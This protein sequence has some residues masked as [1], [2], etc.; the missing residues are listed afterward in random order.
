MGLAVAAHAASV[1][2]IEWVRQP[3]ANAAKV[4]KLAH[5]KGSGCESR[6]LLPRN[7]TGHRRH[8]VPWQAFCVRRP[9]LPLPDP[10]TPDA[11]LTA[12]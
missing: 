3:H 7:H 6:T 9:S 8:P 10:G 12:P 11:T 5:H 2:R 4:V 1:S